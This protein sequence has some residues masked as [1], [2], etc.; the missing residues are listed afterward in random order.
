MTARSN[1][2]DPVFQEQLADA[3]DRQRR[4]LRGPE[5]RTRLTFAFAAVATAVALPLLTESDRHPSWWTYLAFVVAYGVVSSI[6]IEVGSGLALPTELVL[7]PML[8]LLP[9]ALVPGAVV[10]GLLAAGLLEVAQGRVS[11]ARA[12]M[13]SGNGLFALGPALVFLAAGEPRADWHGG[14]VL[15]AAVAAQFVADWAASSLQELLA[16]GI[17]P[18]R[19]LRPLAATFA[20]DALMAPVAYGL[21]VAERFQAGSVLMP[22]PLV[23]LL[24]LFARERRER[25]DSALELSAAYRGTAFLLGDVVEADDP[26]TGEHSRQV[27][28][29]V[30]TVA[31]RLGVDARGVR[32]AELTALLHDV[33]KI[34][35]PARIINK[36]GPLDPDE[37][38][39]I[40]THTV[41][42]ERLLERVG[43]LLAEVGHL[44]RSCHERWDGRG[45]PD[46]L[47]AEQIPLI[48]RIVCCCDAYNAMTTDRPYRRALT[49]AE[50][51]AEVQGNS[52]TQ[53]DPQ[54]AGALVAVVAPR[55]HGG[56]E[57]G[58]GDP[59]LP[60]HELL[61]SAAHLLQ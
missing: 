17:S 8:F 59:A 51:I 12:L 54:V 32:L 16:L 29:L 9:A 2:F 36:P 57:G 6:Q 19:L 53:F 3:R 22:I 15:V 13:K 58:R 27:V 52:G 4:G 21:A 55:A 10:G 31:E 20:I 1:S 42:G 37:R 49:A 50:A 7:V 38:A 34:R 30:A 39:L 41:E 26:Y 47:A 61:A 43:G 44:V 33:G 46:G 60:L 45:Y 14:L 11:L 56:S 28:G 18:R 5:A 23:V 24:I 35:I 48:S 40:E 25:L